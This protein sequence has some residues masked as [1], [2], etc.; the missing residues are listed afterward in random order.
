MIECVQ[1][2]LR[3]DWLPLVWAAK[4]NHTQLATETLARTGAEA[5]KHGLKVDVNQPETHHDKQHPVHKAAASGATPLLDLLINN[6]AQ[7]DVLDKH[8]NSVISALASLYVPCTVVHSCNG[9]SRKPHALALNLAPR[10]SSFPSSCM[11]CTVLVPCPPLVNLP[12]PRLH[13]Q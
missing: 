9:P 13:S 2:R 5:E 3:A 6:G 10:F 1:M 11:P 12:H 4:F 7:L 8:G